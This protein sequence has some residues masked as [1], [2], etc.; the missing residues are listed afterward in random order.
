MATDKHD[1]LVLLGEITGAHGI[2]GDVLVRTYTAEPEAIASYGDVTD[3]SGLKRYSIRVVRVTDKGI[4]ARINAIADRNGAEA[5]RGTKLYIE[6]KQLP[7]AAEQEYYYD[8]LIGLRAIAP[9]GQSIGTV[10]AVQNFGAGDLLE[11]QPA[12]G[13][14]T[15]FIP[16]VDEWV[17]HVDVA[18]GTIVIDRRAEDEDESRED[19]AD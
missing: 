18:A 6:R 7:P 11:V 13:A 15:E 10:V 5:L 17:P 12:S 19:G 2:R 16:F 8:D 14:A 3:A 9:D 4:V 1:K